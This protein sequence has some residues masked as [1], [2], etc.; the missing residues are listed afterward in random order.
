[1][2]DGRFSAQ[3]V[4]AGLKDFQRSTVNYVFERLYGEGSTKRFLVADEVGLGK[5]LVARGLIAR[6]LEH[7]QDR[8]KRIN[9]VYV[10]SNASIAAQN[11]N[12]LN[13]SGRQEFALASRLTLLPIQVCRLA[14]NNVNFIALTPG[15]TFDLKS[16]G[17]IVMERAL[18]FKMLRG[19]DWDVGYGLFNLLQATV[20]RHNWKWWSK[21]W[22]PTINDELARDFR[23]VIEKDQELVARLHACCERFRDFRTNVPL[24]E[25]RERYGLLGQLRHRLARTCIDALEPNLVILD[26]FQRFRNLL[27]GQDDAAKLARDLF[28]FRDVRTLLLSATP[29]KMLSLDHE[30]DDDHYPDFLRTL[31]FLFQD[32]TTVEEL[33][34]DIQRFRNQ[35]FAL[36]SDRND[37]LRRARDRLQQSL[38]RV[39]CRTERI[40]MTKGLDAMLVEPSRMAV[41][42]PNDLDQAALA[43][44]AAR[45]VGA[46]E[47]IEY[48]KSS[49]YLLN[50]LKHYDL[51]RRIDK[52]VDTPPAGLLDVL[53]E[54]DGHLLE[55]G[56]FEEYRSIDPASP[57][58]RVLFQ[59][60]LDK[61]MWRL[62]WMPPALP[63]S[64]PSGAYADVGDVTKALVFSAWNFVPD[65]IAAICSY[66]AER[67]MIEAHDGPVRYSELYDRL[68]PLLRFAKGPDGR[69][70]GMPVIVWL[71]PSPTLA[72]TVDPLALAL[73]KHTGKPPT[74]EDVLD[75]AES[76][77]QELVRRLPRGGPGSRPDERWYW[78]APALLE[79]DTN[80]ISWVKEGWVADE[81]DHD[82]GKLF[83]DHLVQ[84]RSAAAGALDLGPQPDDLARVLAELALAAPGICAL[85]ALRRVAPAL[86][87]DDDEL[88]SAAA[89]IASGF[90]MLYNLPQTIGLLSGRGEGSY[91]RR[92]LQYGI[93]GNLQAVLDEQ[94]HVLVEQPSP[95]LYPQ[96]V[97]D[98]QECLS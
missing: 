42:H 96:I 27:D 33:R 11:I 76:R 91:W 5:T 45:A 12:R 18:I 84:F 37:D 97:L 40:G 25:S 31:C 93:E 55:S 67:R 46:R 81:E 85:R 1:M 71:L 90:R 26:E 6:A 50:F 61:G 73:E 72:A 95:A 39:M 21:D 78:A 92:T 48:W 53:R 15:T 68:R 79:K 38:L 35:L 29:Y 28:A 36:N 60:T 9:V 82:P 49:P 2:A 77:C 30:Q 58:M 3:P 57:R 19:A 56:R 32:K 52:V 64:E 8:I 88:L 66:E 80:V 16:R 41:L 10:C 43:D 98:K 54:A 14:G 51:R 70:T 20:M 47:P 44:G 83:R 34:D 24:N 69:L 63:Y 62:L 74:S 4:L 87:A 86:R 7:L 17:G 13:V 59:D 94:V 65:A 22:S 23:A 75:A 89:R